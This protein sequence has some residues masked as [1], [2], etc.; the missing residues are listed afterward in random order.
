MSDINSNDSIIF[1]DISDIEEVFET[2]S[3]SETY[4]DIDS[5]IDS[6]TDNSVEDYIIVPPHNTV[7][8]DNKVCIH[9]STIWIDVHMGNVVKE[10][11]YY[12][13]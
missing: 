5:D 3:E 12:M 10:I 6:D 2:E 8:V 4:S 9:L 13:K 1:S 7:M 11:V